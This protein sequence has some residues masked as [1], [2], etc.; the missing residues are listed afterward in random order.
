MDPKPPPFPPAN[1]QRPRS[2]R[3]LAIAAVVAAFII[4][5]VLTGA[6][7]STTGLAAGTALHGTPTSI[8]AT[9]SRPVLRVAAFNMHSGI[10]ADKRR[11]L[12]RVAQ[13]LR[14]FDIVGLNEVRGSGLFGDEDQ[15]QIL[16]EKT[17]LPYLYA[18]AERQ[19]W[20]D[21]FGNAVLCKVPVLEWHRTPLPRSS[22]RGYKNVVHLRTSV[23]GREVQVLITHIDRQSDRERQIQGVF[24]HFLE[25]PEPAILAGDFNSR[26]DDPLMIELVTG[27]AQPRK[28]DGRVRVPSGLRQIAQMPRPTDPFASLSDRIDWIL[29][30]G[31]KVRDSG[32][33]ETNASDHP[34]LW[35]EVEVP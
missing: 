18:P 27:I 12:D 30:R 11:D 2:Y 35:V 6:I 34:L 14:G 23:A 25:L 28:V 32:V 8:P 15:A 5:L 9:T 33:V 4:C 29:V 19:W 21:A 26:P 1:A 24:R 20:H 31:L 17:A 10:G 7:R 22:G 16:G 3:G 13:L